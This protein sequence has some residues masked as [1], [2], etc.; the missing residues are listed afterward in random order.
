[1]PSPGD[2]AD[3]LRI[4]VGGVEDRSLAAVGAVFGTAILAAAGRNGPGR[5][6]LRYSAAGL[7]WRA[8][9]SATFGTAVPV[10]SDGD[11]LVEDGEDKSKWVRVRA[12]AA[13]LPAGLVEAGILLGDR[14][15]NAIGGDDVDLS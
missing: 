10:A 13:K 8:P 1:M 15:G 9:G 11:F 2:N 7:Q 12:K 5:A 3:S 14:F 4:E 6:T